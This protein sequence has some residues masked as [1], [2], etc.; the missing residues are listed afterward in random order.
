MREQC[1][2]RGHLAR[3]PVSI[4]EDLAPSEQRSLPFARE[5]IERNQAPSHPHHQRLR[6]TRHLGSAPMRPVHVSCRELQPADA[7]LGAE[8]MNVV[9]DELRHWDEMS[10]G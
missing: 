1:R 7:L 10:L 3:S 9:G 4:I 5:I 8:Y 2:R 6:W